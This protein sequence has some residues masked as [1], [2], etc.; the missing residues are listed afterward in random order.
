MSLRDEIT[1]VVEEVT[2]CDTYTAIQVTDNIMRVLKDNLPDT[3]R[4]IDPNEPAQWPE[5]VK[6][7]DCGGSGEK[8]CGFFEE[9]Y[10]YEYQN[11]E[12]DCIAPDYEEHEGDCD[13]CSHK[14]CP[15][16]TDGYITEWYEKGVMENKKCKDCHLCY[17]G[18]CHYKEKK[19]ADFNEKVQVLLDYSCGRFKIFRP[20]TWLELANT[21]TVQKNVGIRDGGHIDVPGFQGKEIIKRKVKL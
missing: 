6:C 9:T 19:S 8:D 20:L 13:S 4:L 5:K 2:R 17:G 3:S 7:G 11:Y 16:C 1:R 21:T 10:C 12:Y 15:S 18:F 14:K